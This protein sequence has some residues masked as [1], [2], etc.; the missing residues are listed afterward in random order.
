LLVFASGLALPLACTREPLKVQVIHANS[1]RGQV[2]A[3]E[4]AGMMRG[5]FSLLSGAIK[6]TSA[7]A[8]KTPVF[9]IA[10]YNAYHGSPEAYFTHGRQW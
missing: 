5:G 1:L 3:V 9:T 10:V 2:Q 7:A 6:A 4:T 8:G